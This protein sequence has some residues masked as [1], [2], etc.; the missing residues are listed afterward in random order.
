MAEEDQISCPVCWIIPPPPDP[1]NNNNEAVIFA[2]TPCNHM[3]CL[4]CIERILLPDIA[5]MGTCPM[6]RTA[7]NIFDLRNARTDISLY[8]SN[9]DVASWPSISNNVYK[10]FPNRR[11]RVQMSQRTDEIFRNVFC[12]DQGSIPKLQFNNLQDTDGE[13]SDSDLQTFDFRRYHFHPKSMTFNGR[14]DFA[15]PISRPGGD[16]LCYSYSSFKCLLQFS[17][18]G[19]YVRDGYIFW[20]FERTTATAEEYPL[21]GKWQVDWDGRESIEIYVQKH[22]FSCHSVNYQIAIDDEHRPVFEWPLLVS[23]LFRQQRTVVQRS[24]SR[25]PPGT[26]GPRVGETLEWSTNPAY[27]SKIVWKRISM[28]LSPQSDGRRLRIR[29]GSFVYRNIHFQEQLPPYI[30]TS[31][32]GNTFCQ[33]YTVGMASY[34]FENKA[35]EAYDDFRAFIS[36]EHRNTSVWP[37][38]DNGEN[39]PDRVPF[40][41]IE[42][43]PESRIFKGEIC[44][45][46]DYNTTWMGEDKWYYEM[47]FDPKFMFIVSG[48]C[49]RSN[50]S[51]HQF[52]QDLVYVNAAL[53][54][55]LRE[56]RK[57]TTTGRYLDVVRSWR[58]DG[59][60]GPTLNMLGEISMAVLDGKEESIIDFNL[61]R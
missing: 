2:K 28:E 38:L 17:S 24:N 3:Y 31:L 36:Y 34:H 12:F 23:G 43:N 50:S 51:E 14:I 30:A 29:P 37:D 58:Q 45:Q 20:G 16:T 40:R 53:E 1:S 55:V 6:C 54:S 18:D 44:W 4:T 7:V 32:W 13:N 61:Y 46:E 52:G 41:N 33:G 19:N 11:R 60:S 49:T 10:Q 25:I 27:Y 26:M 48:T 47:K 8:P 59:A 56:I 5:T 22:S 21:D 35:D 42:W 9:S 15:T 39:V 57:V